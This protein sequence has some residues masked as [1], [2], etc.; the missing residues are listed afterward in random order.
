[1]K[2]TTSIFILLLS[3]KKII[4]SFIQ[5]HSNCI[6]CRFSCFPY[7]HHHQ[8]ITLNELNWFFV[9]LVSRIDSFFSKSINRFCKSIFSQSNLIITVDY[10]FF[11]DVSLFF[12]VGWFIECMMIIIIG[13]QLSLIWLSVF[14]VVI[15]VVNV[16]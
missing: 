13:I 10:C 1:M 5:W 4:H 3:G 8:V 14:V 11:F 12:F 15:Q 9:C 16:I 2:K 7:Y 6:V